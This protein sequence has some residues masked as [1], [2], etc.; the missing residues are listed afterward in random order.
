MEYTENQ[1]QHKESEN[2]SAYSEI[3]RQGGHKGTYHFLFYSFI[4]YCI[5]MNKLPY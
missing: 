5:F 3:V 1:L 2:L 4:K